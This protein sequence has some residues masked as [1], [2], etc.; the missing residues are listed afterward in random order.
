VK[1]FRWSTDKN[2]S[3]KAERNISF[4]EVVLAIEGGGLKNLLVHRNQRRYPWQVVLVVAYR[5]YVYLVPSVE[6]STP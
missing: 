1:P 3:L 2:E 4:E 5:D 6:E